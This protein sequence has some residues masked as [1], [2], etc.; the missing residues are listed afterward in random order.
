M[1]VE[2]ICTPI[3]THC[4]LHRKYGHLFSIMQGLLNMLIIKNTQGYCQPTKE[5]ICYNLPL[6]THDEDQFRHPQILKLVLCTHTEWILSRDNKHNEIYQKLP[7]KNLIQRQNINSQINTRFTPATN[8][9][10]G[11]YVLIPYCKTKKGIFKKTTITPK[12]T[13]SNN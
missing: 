8:L 9:K 4:N 3:N 10:F 7:K 13:V 6:H 2:V 12:R 5:P 1:R 11:I